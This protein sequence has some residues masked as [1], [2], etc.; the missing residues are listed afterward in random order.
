M[1]LIPEA[2]LLQMDFE[3]DINQI[4]LLIPIFCLP[5]ELACMYPEH[6]KKWVCCDFLLGCCHL[7][8][9]L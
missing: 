8:V 2:V 5:S 7:Q 3:K 1:I 6:M 4:Q 9:G